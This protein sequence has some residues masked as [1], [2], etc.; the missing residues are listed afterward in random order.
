[1]GWSQWQGT[2]TVTLTGNDGSPLGD[3]EV[4]VEVRRRQRRWD[5]SYRWYSSTVTVTTSSDGTA[6][7]P[8][9]PYGRSGN[10]SVREVEVTVVEVAPPAPTTWDGS[11]PSRSA[12]AP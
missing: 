12:D 6:T 7:V 3:A 5:G 8:V 4:E 10:G 9:G 1:V 11:Q 2:S